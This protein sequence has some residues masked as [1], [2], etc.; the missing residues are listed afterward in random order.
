[1]AYRLIIRK[2]AAKDTA[3]A[4]DYYESRQPGL[5]NRFLAA[6]LERYNDISENPRYYGFIDEKHCIRDVKLRH[7]PYLVVYEIEKDAVIIYAVHSA[8]RHPGKRF[9]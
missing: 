7:F 4:F 2:A 3:E 6:V 8:Y 1:M 5:G 9:R